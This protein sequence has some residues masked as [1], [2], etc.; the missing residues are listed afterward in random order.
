VASSEAQI[1]IRGLGRPGD[2]GWV[3]MA[4]GEVYAAEFG[5]NSDFEALVARIVAD[6]AAAHDV[7]RECAWIAELNGRRVGCVFCVADP[8]DAAIAKLRILLVHPDA[9]GHG[10]GGRLVDTCLEFARTAG[11]SKVLL[12]TN[13]PL[14]AARKIYLAR[15][16]GLVKEEPHHSF[17]VDLV[18]QN[19]EL[20]LGRCSSPDPP[21]SISPHGLANSQAATT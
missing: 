8:A 19:Y 20:D 4:H 13:D 11:Y 6:Y 14:A 2:L 15:G 21:G 9:R 17:G 12:W 10:L 5:W 16:F 18:G 7:E 3:V 1:I